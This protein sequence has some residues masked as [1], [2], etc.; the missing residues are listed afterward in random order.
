MFFKVK[1]FLLWSFVNKVKQYFVSGPEV[2]ALPILQ[3]DEEK[4]P[5][6]GADNFYLDYRFG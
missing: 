2:I 5:D 4:K 6:F 1:T 3:W